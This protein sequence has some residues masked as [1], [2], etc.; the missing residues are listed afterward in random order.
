M[1][2]VGAT[3]NKKTSDPEIRKHL[4][5]YL[6]ATTSRVVEEFNV[7]RGISRAD[8]VS[9]SDSEMHG[10][11]IK[12]DIDSLE[13]L[14]RQVHAYSQ[15]FSKMTLVVGLSHLKEALYMIPDWWGVVLAKYDD[16]GD[17]IFSQIR[18]PKMNPSLN[19]ESLLQLLFKDEISV[20][21]RS[22]S[23]YEHKSISKEQLTRH[24]LDQLDIV[25]IHRAVT[26]SLLRRYCA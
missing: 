14:P 11:E 3:K 17:I 5:N 19:G 25:E 4:I 13:R 18:S 12:S 24:L 21:L 10:Y 16:S 23:S 9:I 7:E 8:L 20:V 15:V 1:I 2:A 26:A 22:Q 6:K